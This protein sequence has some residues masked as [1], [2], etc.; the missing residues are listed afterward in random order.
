[1]G[2]A[3]S[4]MLTF[5]GLFKVFDDTPLYEARVS[6]GYIGVYDILEAISRIDT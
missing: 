5:A 6:L 4:M 3:S 2:K 1:M